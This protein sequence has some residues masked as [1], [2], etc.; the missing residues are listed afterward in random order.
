MNGR[1]RG[2]AWFLVMAMLASIAHAGPGTGLGGGL[3]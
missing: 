3:A 2:V 1:M